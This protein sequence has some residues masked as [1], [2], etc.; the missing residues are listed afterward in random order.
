MSRLPSTDFAAATWYA[1]VINE[2]RFFF[3]AKTGKHR[4]RFGVSTF[5][6]VRMAQV[7]R[8]C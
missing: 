4:S 2:I 1:R 6:W 7:A 8:D 5:E 3:G